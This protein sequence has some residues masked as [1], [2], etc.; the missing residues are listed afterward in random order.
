MSN[1]EFFEK[2]ISN[3]ISEQFPA[4]Y[5][6]DGP[7]FVEFVKKYYE[8]MESSN[9]ALYHSRRLPEF[10]DIDETIDEFV[11][12][13][14]EKYLK[15]IQLDTILATRKLI[16]HSLDLYRSKGSERGLELLFKIAFGKDIRIYYPQDDIFKLSDGLWRIPTYL[17]I[18]INKFNG[19]LVNKQIIG[20]KSGATAFVESVVRRTLGDQGF[21]DIL[22][23][24]AINGTFQ[25]GEF[26]DTT[27]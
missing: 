26:L 4:L 2:T 10:R 12:H 24:S 23:L 17:E 7:I 18:T 21:S 25:A 13:F 15:N 19:E 11:L 6:S 5:R 16:K 14:K 20:L 22:F 3:L 27:N 9:N 1:T 8:W